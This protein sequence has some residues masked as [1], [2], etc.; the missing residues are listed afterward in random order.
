MSASIRGHQ[1]TFKVYK[2]GSEVVFDTITRVEINQDSNFTRSFYVGKAI[3][4]GDQTMEGWSGQLEAEVVNDSFDRFI[5][6]LIT[7]NLRGIGVSQY[8]FLTTEF[9]PNGTSATYVYFDC[10]FRLSKSQ[11]GLNEKMTKRLDFQASGRTRI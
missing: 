1:G 9:Y 2:D 7:G 10:Q 8:T 6:A 5:D 11:G 4:K 3:P